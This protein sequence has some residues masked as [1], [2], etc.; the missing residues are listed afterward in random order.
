MPKSDT[1]FKS[2]NKMGKGRPKGAKNKLA[3]IFTT[4]LYK[5][6]KENGVEALQRLREDSP[7]EYSRVIASILPKDIN[8]DGEVRNS[9]INAQPELSPEEWAE[10]H[11]P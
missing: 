8:F 11:K 4:A 10:K 5:D 6:F 7:G 1:Q 2:G 3:L 9:V